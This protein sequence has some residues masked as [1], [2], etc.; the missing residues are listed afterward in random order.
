MGS[1]ASLVV[2]VGFVPSPASLA[3]Y[4]LVRGAMGAVSTWIFLP[5]LALTLVAGLLAIAVNRAYHNAG[6]AWVKLASGILVF[7]GGFVSVQGP[8]QEEAERSAAALAGQ[9]N[10]ATLGGSL[11]AEQGTLWALLVIAAANV[12]LGIW[13]PRLSLRPGRASVRDAGRGRT[14][15]Q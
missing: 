3:E 4:A 5:S 6:W 8:M 12:A 11:S 13:R 7:E 15:A 9:I 10:P 14:E 2:L 1:M